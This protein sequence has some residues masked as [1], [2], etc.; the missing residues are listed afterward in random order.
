METITWSDGIKS[1]QMKILLSY[2]YQP[3]KEVR[4]DKDGLDNFNLSFTRGQGIFAMPDNI[5]TLALHI[6]AQNISVPTKVL[7][8]PTLD[9]F[10]KELKKKY[11]FVG[12]SFPITFYSKVLKMAK[13]V[14]E[15]SPKTKVVVGGYGVQCFAQEMY[16]TNE[17]KEIVD[18][19]CYGEGIQFFREL[20]GEKTDAHIR[21]LFPLGGFMPF[22]RQKL[23]VKHFYLVVALGCKFGCDF[24]SPSAFFNKKKVYLLSPKQC[25]QLIKLNLEKYPNVNQCLIYDEDFL[26]NKKYVLELG[27]YLK[28]DE[29]CQRRN[30]CY[31]AFA[32]INSISQYTVEELIENNIAG[33][34]LGVE[35]CLRDLFTREKMEKRRG[36]ELKEIFDTFNKYG[37]MSIA[38]FILGWDFHT[39]GNIEADIDYYVGLKPTMIQLRPL[40][41]IPQTRLWSRLEKEDR[42]NDRLSWENLD[43]FS[44]CMRYKNFTAKEIWEYIDLATKRVNETHGPSQMRIFELDLN[45]YKNLKQSPNPF[46]RKRAEFLKKEAK[47]LYPVI[48]AIM[49]YPYNDT[50]YNKAKELEEEYREMFGRPEIFDKLATILVN[51]L[52]RKTKKQREKVNYNVPQ[53]QFREFKYNF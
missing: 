11:D 35:S 47:L 3:F 22:W 16:S 30:F 52:A 37:I 8:Y 48:F 46:L 31:Y 39:R 19:I 33:L 1:L 34:Y 53:P 44:E 13:L 51:T 43:L 10:R 12:I 17:L 6:I 32:S 40:L 21:Q 38:T 28:N 41:P 25:Y 20:L 4:E 7:E 2:P 14:K 26:L 15:I 49:K 50:V 36:K 23:M 9:K 27:R 29:E 42:L 18:Y 24:C 45:G 5:P